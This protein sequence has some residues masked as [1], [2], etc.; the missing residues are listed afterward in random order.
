MRL[1]PLS[2]LTAQASLLLLLW[3]LQSSLCLEHPTHGSRLGQRIAY[4]PT[5]QRGAQR[6]LKADGETGFKT[7]GGGSWWVPDAP[8]TSQAATNVDS[9][10]PASAAVPSTAVA[11]AEAPLSLE[12]VY[13]LP[14]SGAA[15]AQAAYGNVF[16]ASKIS[17]EAIR[18][19]SYA[20]EKPAMGDS[21]TIDASKYPGAELAD[22]SDMASIQD[23]Q[24]LASGQ[25]AVQPKVTPNLPPPSPPVP[26]V[27]NC[28]GYLTKEEIV[29]GLEYA[30]GKEYMPFEPCWDVR[31]KA[32]QNYYGNPGS[33]FPFHYLNPGGY[34]TNVTFWLRALD[35]YKKGEAPY[36]LIPGGSSSGGNGQNGVSVPQNADGTSTVTPPASGTGQSPTATGYGINWYGGPVVNNKNGIVIYYIWYGA[37]GNLNNNG[38]ANQPTTVKVLTDMAQSM[39]G[40]PWFGTATT[41]YDNNGKVPNI[42]KYGGRAVVK[43]GPCYQG[44]SLSNDQIFNSVDCVIQRGILP[45]ATNAVYLLLGASNVK[46][47][48]GMCTNYCG[49][50]TYGFDS[51]NRQTLFGFIGSPLPCLNACTAQGANNVLA[52][53]NY[54]AEADG[55]ASIIAHETMEVSTDPL[56]NAWYNTDGYENA[57]LCAWTFGVNTFSAGG[58][59]ANVKWACP[60]AAK[61]SGCTDRF[62]LIQQNWVNQSPGYCALRVG[63]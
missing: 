21:S 63:G 3:G 24:S 47:T 36:I 28:S 38:T 14:S 52:S 60:A 49:W 35:D 40:K 34:V 27:S 42:V 53:P 44:A 13:T 43:N 12:G 11:A 37:W 6:T 50:H 7:M 18:A 23:A 16:L 33:V 39:G 10:T 5:H 20:G 51:R 41:Y 31:L 19:K 4:L 61:R 48:S 8:S 55:M 62:Y 59:L 1:P 54:N 45:Y 22:T 56:I 46:A 30:A 15:N 29:G 57:D 25:L 32:L 9:A 58:G 2:G 17:N 26:T